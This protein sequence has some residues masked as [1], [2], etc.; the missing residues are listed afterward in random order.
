MA[1]LAGQQYIW[2]VDG[3]VR[4]W[5]GCTLHHR[6]VLHPCPPPMS[7]THVLHPCPPSLL[8]SALKEYLLLKW[9][10]RSPFVPLQHMLNKESALLAADKG[11]G[12]AEEGDGVAKGD[13]PAD[14][15]SAGRRAGGQLFCPMP[16]LP[17]YPGAVVQA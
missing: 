9:S 3:A 10:V 14:Q 7:S 1:P 11:K 12:P 13:G 5:E 15:A 4:V 6:H 16:P 2:R 17:S 8:S